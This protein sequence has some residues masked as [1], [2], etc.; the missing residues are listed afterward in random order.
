MR[1]SSE[2]NQ[3]EVQAADKIASIASRF[4]DGP[5]ALVC[6]EVLHG[7]P[8][9]WV[10]RKNFIWQFG[11]GKDHSDGHVWEVDNDPRLGLTIRDVVARD[12]SV[13]EVATLNDHHIAY[14][15]TTSGPWVPHDDTTLWWF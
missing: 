9:L 12:P 15:A 14:R 10:C 13:G 6:T 8:I 2:T 11:C 1:T 5:R 4:R 3:P 7:A